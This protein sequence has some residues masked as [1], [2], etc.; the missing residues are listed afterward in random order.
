MLPRIRISATATVGYCP[1]VVRLLVALLTLV[2]VREVGIPVSWRWL[3]LLLLRFPVALLILVVLLR[4]NG[5]L[6]H[7]LRVAF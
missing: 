3:L 6:L 5:E 2:T 7:V 1:L 4:E